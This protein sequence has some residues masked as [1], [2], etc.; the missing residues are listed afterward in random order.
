[1]VPQQGHLGIRQKMLIDIYWVTDPTNDWACVQNPHLVHSFTT[2][3][4][5]AVQYLNQ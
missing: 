2:S 4:I 5:I 3:F 1:M